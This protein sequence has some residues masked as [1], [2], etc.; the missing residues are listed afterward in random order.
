MAALLNDADG[1]VILA[2]FQQLLFI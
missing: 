1:P 2:K